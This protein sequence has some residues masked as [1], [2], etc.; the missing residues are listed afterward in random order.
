[1]LFYCRY[2]IYAMDDKFWNISLM[3]QKYRECSLYVHQLGLQ[4][5]RLYV[6]FKPYRNFDKV[7]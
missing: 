5:S 6:I 4:F 3:G 7:W 2:G 1:M